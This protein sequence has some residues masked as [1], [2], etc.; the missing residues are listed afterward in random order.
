MAVAIRG[1]NARSSRGLHGFVHDLVG[2]LNR[3][4]MSCGSPLL[5]AVAAEQ[6]WQC[7][8]GCPICGGGQKVSGTAA[9]CP[10]AMLAIQQASTFTTSGCTHSAHS[11]RIY[12]YKHIRGYSFGSFIKHIRGALRRCLRRRAPVAVLTKSC[13]GVGRALATVLCTLPAVCGSVLVLS[14]IFRAVSAARSVC[15]RIC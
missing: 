14:C 12:Q 3:V 2:H 6:L 4:A 8:P 11:T 7:L 9:M 15:S 5:C 1:A 13:S 10:Q